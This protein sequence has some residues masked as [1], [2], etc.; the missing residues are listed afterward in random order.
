MGINN[1]GKA[2]FE[3]KAY[4]IVL[5][6]SKEHGCFEQSNKDLLILVGIP[7]VLILLFYRTKVL[8]QTL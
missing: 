5:Q 4:K 2:K 3:L 6:K 1:K 7:V 8:V